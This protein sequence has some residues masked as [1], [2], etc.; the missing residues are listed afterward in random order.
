MFN[1]TL[2]CN[3]NYIHNCKLTPRIDVPGVGA[4][5][6]YAKSFPE[7]PFAPCTTLHDENR[8]IS[9][10]FTGING[11]IGASRVNAVLRISHVFVRSDFDASLTMHPTP[12]HRRPQRGHAYEQNYRISSRI[13]PD[14]PDAY[15]ADSSRKSL[16]QLR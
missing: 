14:F 9:S 10:K 1:T 6:I 13:F 11:I 3:M 15:Y 12:L 16:E 5:T 7:I 2:C 4:E 8:A